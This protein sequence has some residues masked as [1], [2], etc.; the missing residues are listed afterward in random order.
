MEEKINLLVAETIEKI[1]AAQDVKSLG[2]I[3]VSVLG[4]NGTLTSFMRNLKDLPNEEK[5]KVGKFVNEAR[6]VLEAEFEKKGNELFE[7]ELAA[8]LESEKIDVTID[9]PSRPLGGRHPLNIVRRKVI[10][11]F[12]SMGF[13]VTDSPEIETDY[14]NFEALNI[15]KD[16]PAR[17]M[18]DTFYVVPGKILLRTQTSAGQ[19][20][21]MEKNK[22]P[23]KMINVG[24]VYRSD[25]IDAT[26]SPVF[27]QIEGLVVDEKITMCDLKG[28]LEK[29]AKFFFGEAT[30]IRFRPSYF[31]FTEPSVEVD[32]SCPHCKGKGCRVCKGTGWIEILGAGM[33]N[34]HVLEG[35]DIDPDKF[36]GFAFGIGLDRIT[37]I[38]YGINDMRQEFENDVRFLKQFN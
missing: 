18:Q 16:H 33:V 6:N 14:Y 25:D 5:P 23:I 1:S 10:D 36:T 13:V 3:K 21:T 19:I 8:S 22:P 30:Q 34:R 37:T 12:T 28:M 38:V 11:F 4:K 26:H 9:K 15:P 27:H 35:C 7:K 29:F 20:R 17:E 31:P 24:K 32:A 2:D